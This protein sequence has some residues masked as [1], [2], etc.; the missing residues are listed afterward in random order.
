M[1]LSFYYIL[2]GYLRLKPTKLELH[3]TNCDIT[4]PA[5]NGFNWTTAC[6]TLGI[7]PNERSSMLVSVSGCS[8]SKTLRRVSITLMF[9]PSVSF[10]SPCYLYVPCL[11]V[12]A[13][14]RLQALE[15]S[16]FYLNLQ[17]LPLLPPSLLPVRHREGSHARQR[18]WMVNLEDPETSLH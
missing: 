13:D 18:I 8:A 7:A 2:A 4:L 17:H 1:F 9:S 12:F 15:V 5:G 3:K 10:N 6:F 16:L 11:S 14:A